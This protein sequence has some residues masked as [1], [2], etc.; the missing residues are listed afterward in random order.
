VNALVEA[1]DAAF[2]YNGRAVVRVDRIALLAGECIGLFGPNGSGKTT[3]VRGL[4]GLLPAL[5][6]EVRCAAGLRV[7]YVPQS[8]ALELHWPMS[9]FDVA[10][11]A[12]SARQ[13]LGWLRGQRAAV[14]AW[15][16]RL[17]LAQLAGRRFASLS[18][19]QQQRIILA[20]ALATEPQ[21]L[22]LDE[23]TGGLDLHNRQA[24]LD[25]VR[26]C[27][28]E[29]ICAVMISHDI[30]DLQAVARRVLWLRPAEEAHKPPIAQ[31]VAADELPARIA[32]I[33]AALAG[34]NL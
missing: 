14:E 17:G 32:E 19:G 29:G 20:G 1:R 21:L 27:V 24:F 34:R 8:R 7:G 26:R 5:A 13:P 10:S 16:A 4:C 25:Q 18:G 33:A 9:G 30:E 3:L 6:G 28:G 12:L 31:W 22:V 15:L 2:G 11:L 23:P